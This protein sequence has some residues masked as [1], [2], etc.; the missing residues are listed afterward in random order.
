[1]FPART[2]LLACLLFV[3]GLAAVSAAAERKPSAAQAA[4][5][6]G[7]TVTRAAAPARS[8]VRS[9]TGA[10]VATFTDGA[11]TV[12]LAGPA[13]TFSEAARQVTTSTWVRV[14]AA[15]FAGTVDYA[16]L[17]RARADRSPDVLA[18]AFEFVSGRPDR[19]DASGR[20]IAGDASYGP[21]EDDDDGA[22]EE[23]SDWNDLQGVTARYGSVADPPEP[24]Q[25]QSLDCSG[26]MRMLWGVRI[27]LPLGLDPD[28]WGVRAV[29]SRSLEPNG[30]WLPRRS[31]QQATAGPGVV[32]IANAGKR[33]SD[34][35]RL[36]PGDLVFFDAS[37]D[38]GAAIDH[39]GLYLGR[40]TAGH[41]RFISSRESADG[42]TMGDY[43]GA[44][45]LDGTG[46]YAR[47]FRSTRRL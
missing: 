28:W 23:G 15:P 44:S 46:L 24:E 27:G 22:R 13:R 43:N 20:L 38:D 18:T 40:D 6:S 3:F 19:R 7:Y 11:R 34:F 29:F 33:V 4:T 2:A 26:F 17:D 36:Q 31:S 35:T 42:P 39:V 9:S 16:W 8:V 45:L 41:K 12:A 25:T 14:L 5:A 1:V 37:V 21:L 32:P 30:R 10:W 47:S